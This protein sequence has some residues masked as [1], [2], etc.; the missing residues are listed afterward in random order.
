MS[1]AEVDTNSAIMAATYRAV[2][3]HGYADLT[4][5]DIADEFEKS[6]SLL[7]YHYDTKEDLLVAFLE[8]LVDQFEDHLDELTSTDRPPQDRL[9]D[10]I[11]GFTVEP[12]ET[13]RTSLHL[14]LLEMRSQAQR[15]ERF[16]EQF[17]R[18][19][20]MA[21]GAFS[22]LIEEGQA[23]GYFDPSADADAIAQL[24]F[25][26]M[27]GARARQITLGEDGYAEAV[28]VT[29]YRSVIEPLLIEDR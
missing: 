2:C 21:R 13:E 22:S 28:G 20:R 17:V 18:S 9:R 7:H 23:S 27:D 6:K 26:A 24:L 4:M 1:D 19:D 10:Y 11:E 12:D 14:A 3:S 29:L 5:Q 15:N 8:H 25:A 16:R